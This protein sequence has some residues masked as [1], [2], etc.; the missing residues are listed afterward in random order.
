MSTNWLFALSTTSVVIG[1]DGKEREVYV[2][3]SF[4][5]KTDA[6]KKETKNMN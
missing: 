2:V 4:M 5:N 6:R 1:S 3:M